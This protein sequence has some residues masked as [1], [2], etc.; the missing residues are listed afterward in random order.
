MENFSENAKKKKKLNVVNWKS[1]YPTPLLQMVG[2]SEPVTSLLADS[3][4]PSVKQEFYNNS[5]F[6]SSG[7]RC[8]Y[9]FS[10]Y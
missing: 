6:P 3:V 10:I 1:V 4:D 7:I 5:R 2:D 8:F 9:V